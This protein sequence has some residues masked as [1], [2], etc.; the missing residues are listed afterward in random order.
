MKCNETARNR[1]QQ[2]FLTRLMAY[3]ENKGVILFQAIAGYFM[4]T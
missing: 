4:D 2:E 1:K 3:I